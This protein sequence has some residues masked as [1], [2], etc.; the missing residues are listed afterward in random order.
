ML[1]VLY[2]SLVSDRGRT[3]LSV[4]AVGAAIVVVIA[5]EGF[6]TGLWRQVRAYPEQLPVQLVAMQAGAAN[7]N[8]AKSVIPPAVAAQAALTPG[9][10][11]V[12]PLVRIPVI[13]ETDGRKTPI[14]IVGYHETGGPWSLRAGRP[15]L[16]PGEV[17][18]D[19]ALARKHR[20]EPGDTLNLLGREMRIAGTSNETSS[21]FG[22]LVFVRIEDAVAL[23]SAAPPGASADASESSS[24]YLLL[25][26]DPATPLEE[27][28]RALRERVGAI[29]VFTPAELADADLAM[30]QEL[31]ASVMNLLVTVAY[32]AGI[33]VVGL[34]LYA[35]VF[36]RLREFGIMKAL[37]ARDGWLQGQVVGQAIAVTTGGLVVG[38]LA[39]AGLAALVAEFMPEFLVVVW[40]PGV[41]ARTAAASIAMAAVA[42][43]VPIRQVAG[44]DPALVFRR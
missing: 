31:M 1:L 30:A 41:L 16:A 21:L 42:S 7:M 5:L 27:V 36:E 11:E 24:G 13:F 37:G 9:V 29:D 19:R 44:V 38:V 32:A 17:V 12:H 25:T 2:R 28:R 4:L 8:S 15:P 14:T 3:I 43:L 39:S 10:E 26:T 40:D 18:M 23:L 35:A 22:S 34:T 20:L 6:K 33:M